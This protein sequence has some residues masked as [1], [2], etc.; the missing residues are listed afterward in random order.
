MTIKRMS[1]PRLDPGTEKG[2]QLVEKLLKS[3]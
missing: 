3:K 1:D 2:K